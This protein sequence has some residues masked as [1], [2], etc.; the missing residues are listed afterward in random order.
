MLRKVIVAAALIVV[1]LTLAV[2][3]VYNSR[4]ILFHTL[5]WL[6]ASAAVL[7]IIS[8]S[9]R[10]LKLNTVAQTPDYRVNRHTLDTFLEHWGTAA[11]I[12]IL[13]VSGFFMRTG[14]SRIFSLNLHF[15][16]LVTMLYFGSYFLAHFVVAKK[17][18]YLLPRIS[19]I[20]GGTVKKY[21]LRAAWQEKGK[22]LSSQKSAFLVFAL[23]GIGVLVTGAIKL[24]SY[25]FGIPPSLNQSATRAH[26]VFAGL[27]V[28]ML[29]VHIIFGLAARSH[30]HLLK[31]LFTGKNGA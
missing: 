18:A 1:I 14:Y 17:Y 30:R 24:A 31:S 3:G 23:L 4:G 25:Y 11:G 29:L 20:T 9:Y 7:G 19:D 5:P 6:I 16:G 15:L 28:L 8:G 2:V 22:Y 26:D 21:L 10:G 27:F 13:I 12:L